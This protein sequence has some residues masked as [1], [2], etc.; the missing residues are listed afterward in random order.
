MFVDDILK[1]LSV[2]FTIQYSSP[3]SCSNFVHDCLICILNDCINEL[4]N[5]YIESDGTNVMKKKKRRKVN[6]DTYINSLHS[7]TI[8]TITSTITSNHLTTPNKTPINDNTRL[9]INTARFSILE[10]ILPS[11]K[12]SEEGF[13]IV[14]KF[15]DE[16]VSALILERSL[17]NGN[18]VAEDKLVG[19]LEDNYRD[20]LIGYLLRSYDDAVNECSIKMLISK[21]LNTSNPKLRSRIIESLIKYDMSSEDDKAKEFLRGWVTK[22][23]YENV[24]F[25]NEFFNEFFNDEEGLEVSIYINFSVLAQMIKDKVSQPSVHRSER[26]RRVSRVSGETTRRFTCTRR[27]LPRKELDQNKRSYVLG[28]DRSARAAAQ[29]GSP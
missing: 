25:F 17:L 10:T 26:E 4:C 15:V 11:L 23:I 3:S 6:T 7:D 21:L 20:G 8:D 22:R 24:G 29:G 1:R 13:K 16:V 9:L 5:V 28:L 27:K 18:C 12:L 19:I 14:R 2:Q